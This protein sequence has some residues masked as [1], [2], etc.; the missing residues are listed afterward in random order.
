MPAILEDEDWL[1]WLGEEDQ[2]PVDAKA[3]LKTMEGV[4]WTAALEPKGTS[5]RKSRPNASAVSAV[6]N[7]TEPSGAALLL[8]NPTLVESRLLVDGHFDV[9]QSIAAESSPRS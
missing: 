4:N 8:P 1:V 5:S 3:V 7:R 9:D 2:T 6:R